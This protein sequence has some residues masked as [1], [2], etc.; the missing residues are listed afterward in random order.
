MKRKYPVSLFLIGF[1]T[2]VLFRN[3]WLFIPSVI[4]LIVGLFVKPCLY[5][6]GGLL[7]LDVLLSLIGQLRIRHAFL[8]ESDNPDFQAFQDAVSEKGNWMEGV[9]GFVEKQMNDPENQV[10]LPSDDEREDESN[11][12]DATNNERP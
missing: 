3:F 5:V 8:Q 2:N 1:I 7:V 12:E 9:M 11:D 4:L 10:H 6:C